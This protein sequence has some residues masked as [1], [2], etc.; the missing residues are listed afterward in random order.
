MIMSGG[1][2]Y[3]TNKQIRT[4]KKLLTLLAFMILCSL[5]DVSAQTTDKCNLTPCRGE[6]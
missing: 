6:G 2:E 1:R 4:M 5:S 3:R